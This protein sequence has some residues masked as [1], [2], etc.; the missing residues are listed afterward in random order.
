MHTPSPASSAQGT[1]GAHELSGSSRLGRGALA[2]V[3]ISAI[4]FILVC[5]NMARATDVGGALTW[6]TQGPTTG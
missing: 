5:A 6:C 2:A 1:P 3:D 4:E